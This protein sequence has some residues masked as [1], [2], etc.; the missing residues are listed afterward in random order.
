M[1]GRHDLLTIRKLAAAL[2]GRPS[3]NSQ[4]V[5]ALGF[6]VLIVEAPSGASPACSF[7][8]DGQGVIG[9]SSAWVDH[10]LSP[11]IV[12]HAAA[13]LLMGPPDNDA[14]YLDRWLAA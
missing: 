4:L 5:E 8:L 9:L 6:T 13:C 11:L 3:W 12:A 10:E 2:H 7:H 1:L 14:E